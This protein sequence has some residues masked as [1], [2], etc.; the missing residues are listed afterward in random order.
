MLIPEKLLNQLKEKGIEV[1]RLENHPAE[2]RY[3]IKSPQD[4]EHL[5]Y[6]HNAKRYADVVEFI[7]NRYT[8]FSVDAK[9]CDMFES[10]HCDV[11]GNRLTLAQCVKEAKFYKK[12]FIKV[13]YDVF[14]SFDF[15]DEYLLKEQFT[16]SS[17]NLK[18]FC[19]HSG[20]F[21]ADCTPNDVYTDVDFTFTAEKTY[22][23]ILQWLYVFEFLENT[24]YTE[25]QMEYIV[26]RKTN[27][28]KLLVEATSSGMQTLKEEF[29]NNIL[30]D[31]LNSLMNEAQSGESEGD[32]NG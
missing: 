24:S 21:I 19:K 14:S 17:S 15:N 31:A 32:N 8:T 12:S 11:N 29:I 25:E 16:R 26:S 4:V 13:L 9:A 20:H 1:E 10:R 5:L 7:K 6:I 23:S 18:K 22:A 30:P 3:S 27:I 28:A 2:Y